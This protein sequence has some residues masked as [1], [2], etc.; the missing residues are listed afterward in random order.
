MNVLRRVLVALVIAGGP[1]AHA[2]ILSGDVVAGDEPISG[3]RV[4][5]SIYDHLNVQ[6]FNSSVTTGADGKFSFTVPGGDGFL[7]V[8]PPSNRSLLPAHVFNI[9]VVRDVSVRV[10]LETPVRIAGQA[11]SPPGKTRAGLIQYENLARLGSGQRR[12]ENG[13]FDLSVAA[14]RYALH[15]WPDDPT[16]EA[17]MTSVD[18]RAGDLTALEVHYGAEPPAFVPRDPPFAS[19]ITVGS[20]DAAGMTI[21][22]GQPGAV[23]PT[24]SVLVANIQTG[25][26]SF[27]VS[28][29][30][31]SFSA[32]IFA[33]PGSFLEIKH[34]P[35]GRYL[36]HL[37]PFMEIP[38]GTI[39]YVE[40]RDD[41]IVATGRLRDSVNSN[42]GRFRYL[43]GP[44]AGQW[45][46][47]APFE[48][49]QWKPGQPVALAGKLRIISKDL[50]GIEPAAL[51]INGE[52]NAQLIFDASGRQLQ[53]SFQT[54]MSSDLTPTG[55]PITN[56]TTSP[57]RRVGA[58]VIDSRTRISESIIDVEWHIDGRLS[59]SLGGGYC[60]LQFSIRVEGLP[61]A[62]DHPTGV[63]PIAT[64][65]R[66]VH[67][68]IP[69]RIVQMGNAA[70]PRLTW[71]IA[72]NELSNGQRGVL[73]N[74]DRGRFG[75]ASQVVTH[76]GR[77]VLPMFDREGR[78]I[79]YNLDPF[80]PLLSHS[81]GTL[82]CEY[83]QIPLRFPSGEVSVRVIGPDGVVEELG[84]APFVQNRIGSPH[85]AR[86]HPISGSDRTTAHIS[87]MYQLSTLDARF[88]HVFTKHGVHRVL[89]SGTVHDVWGHVYEGGGTYEIDVARPLDIETA[90]LPGT[91]FE[92]GNAISRSLTLFPP[93][94]AEITI[95][96][97]L[98][99]DSDP[100][101]AIR[102]VVTGRA[103]RFG[104]FYAPA[105]I[106]TAAGE[107][108]VDIT[109]RY[110][111][112][113]HDWSASATWGSIIETP[114][115]EILAHGK[116]GFGNASQKQGPWFLVGNATDRGNRHLMYPFLSGDVMWMENAADNLADAPAFTVED[117]QGVFAGR[118]RSIWSQTGRNL[119]ELEE[120]IVTGEISLESECY[121][122]DC[123]RAYAYRVAQ[124]PGVRVRET[125]LE[126]P[127][128][129]VY[130]RFDDHYQLQYGN[131]ANG[132]L[133]N[134]FKF[135]FGGGV[136][137]DPQLLFNRYMAYASLWVLLPDPDTIGGRIMPPFQGNGGGPSG[138][139]LFTLKG[140][141][142]DLFFHPTAVRPG[143]ILHRGSI[144][145][146]AGYSA[147]TL[148][149]KIEIVVTSPSGRV[150]TIAGQANRIGYFYDPSQDFT[151][152]EPGVW[153][154]R[155][156]IV[157][158]GRT[159][160]GQV[161]E[162]FPAGD[163]LGS[164]EGEFY[165]YVVD[166]NA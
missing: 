83:V 87:D 71:M 79:K 10:P 111:G 122:P 40:G 129:F 153:K 63:L 98:L 23:A 152:G 9:D 44:D 141:E 112:E 53:P 70:T 18:V 62:V 25:Q 3:A 31:G 92:V 102:S 136:I 50:A 160:A 68:T 33:P 116:R 11:H 133:P 165:F 115:S 143:T 38:P 54:F 43:G 104:Q 127:S 113:D 26:M 41:E 78:A 24:A 22:S 132:D 106:P 134:D 142:I 72:L 156:R 126:E 120:Q 91:P 67:P 15:L 110:Q 74:E 94:A 125:I 32:P 61:E 84:S 76:S 100:A 86:G 147:P 14:G 105:F 55:L 27:V 75:F 164:R 4:S 6:I 58:L 154:A 16:L 17:V 97:V 1:F 109:A 28:E 118:M 45:I 103:N 59:D 51:A 80:A 39:L 21:V 95:E 13:S 157:F 65:I 73:A 35:S 163:A 30:D 48:A 47:S 114:Q 66:G 85:S 99:P 108:R 69:A 146:F 5:L 139:P 7:N 155:V 159:S 60:Q 107:Y 119:E 90:V 77:T 130:W 12:T 150:R 151:A 135:Q 138:G 89:V 131:G 128:G 124:R 46:L 148:P 52:M 144:A 123:L 137:R 88:E 96:S 34:D 162:P 158:D 29:S 20:P 161:T 145:S 56:M 117:R 140:R 2:H 42:I 36:L 8:S 149:A 19:H 166:A 57:G 37:F 82:P 49:S 101:R 64:P 93:V 81:N 121:E